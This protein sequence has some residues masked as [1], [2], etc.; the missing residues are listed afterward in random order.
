[1][2]FVVLPPLSK[3]FGTPLYIGFLFLNEKT[4]NFNGYKGP[5]PLKNNDFLF[6][7]LIFL[8]FSWLKRYAKQ[9]NQYKKEK[10]LYSTL[11]VKTSLKT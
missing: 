4:V 1:M 8:L 7:L 9:K 3:I 2:I 10:I 6:V 11:E 5:F